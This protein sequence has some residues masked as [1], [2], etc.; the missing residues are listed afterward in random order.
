MCLVFETILNRSALFTFSLQIASVLHE[1]FLIYRLVLKGVK[2]R[3]LSFPCGLKESTP[4]SFVCSILRCACCTV[5]AAFVQVTFSQ[6]KVFR[7]PLQWDSFPL[8]MSVCL[9]N[10]LTSVIHSLKVSCDHLS[11]AVPKPICFLCLSHSRHDICSTVH[12]QTVFQCDSFPPQVFV[13]LVNFLTN[14]IQSC[15]VQTPACS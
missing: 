6:S 15:A 1:R 2:Y 7:T 5:C 4:F 3:F 8:Q 9:M 11:C 13:C 10:F 12:M 14:A